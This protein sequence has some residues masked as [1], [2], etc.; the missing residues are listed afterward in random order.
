MDDPKVLLNLAGIKRDI[1]V[2]GASAGGVLALKRLFAAL[3]A[4]FSA[5][6][7]VV[8]HRG[9]RLSQLASVLGATLFIANYR[10]TWW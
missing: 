6:V 8:L 7:G 2:I 3:P 5:T 10:T 9:G 1:V 4:S